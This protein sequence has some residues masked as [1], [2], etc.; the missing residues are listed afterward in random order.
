M[1]VFIG[2][3][4]IHDGDI[5]S[6][7]DGPIRVCTNKENV[8]M[9]LDDKSEI[10]W[11]RVQNK[12]L[13]FK[14]MFTLRPRYTVIICKPDQSIDSIT[15]YTTRKGGSMNYEKCKTK[16]DSVK[17][18]R[19]ARAATK[20]ITN[21]IQF[22]Q[23]RGHVKREAKRLT[24]IY[25]ERIRTVD[26]LKDRISAKDWTKWSETWQQMINQV[27]RE[28]AEVVGENKLYKEDICYE[29]HFEERMN[30]WRG[31]FNAAETSF[32]KFIDLIRKC[33]ART[34]C[35]GICTRD[36]KQRCVPRN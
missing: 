18:K 15:F 23:L 1:K 17:V 26:G 9:L 5:V 27:N 13:I 4:E 32:A 24:D 36:S 30:R 8:V 25:T 12:D 11:L 14:T 34:F 22:Q 33:E 19:N 2:D 6:K 16:H 28:L 31:T 29:E 10:Q 35:T 7:L 3:S 21:D 20:L